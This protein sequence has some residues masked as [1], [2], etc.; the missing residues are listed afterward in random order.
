[1]AHPLDEIR[2]DRKVIQVFDL[3]KE[4]SQR[5]YWHSKTPEE[6]WEAIELMRMICYGQDYDP[7]TTRLQRLLTVSE[8]GA[9]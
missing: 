8:R 1:M 2:M 3:G 4:P 5:D 6:R 7:I 9:G